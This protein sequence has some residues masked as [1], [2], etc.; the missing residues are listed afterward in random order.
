MKFLI[1]KVVIFTLI[2]RLEVRG[3][4]EGI[5]KNNLILKVPINVDY[6]DNNRQWTD[7]D[8]AISNVDK[9]RVNSEVDTILYFSNETKS[10]C[11]KKEFSY[12]MIPIEHVLKWEVSK[13]DL[14]SIISKE[15]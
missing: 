4:V 7:I 2:N 14:I 3:L 12:Q 15:K 6:I 11:T 13:E 10:R 9:A 8:L 1:N 5:Y